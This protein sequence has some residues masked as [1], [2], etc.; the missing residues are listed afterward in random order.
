VW[1]VVLAC[2][3]GDT[4]PAGAAP[5]APGKRGRIE[6]PPHARSRDV[7]EHARLRLA[8]KAPG[9]A[10]LARGAAAD[11]TRFVV[12]RVD[13]P[14]LAFG[15]SPPGDELHDRFYY[16]N[17]FRY[18]T[19]YF[20]AAS[21]G[22]LHLEF[23]VAAAVART[24]LAAADYGDVAIYDSSMVELTRIAVQSSD[25]EVDFAAY[26]GVLLVHAGPGQESDVA[27][28]SPTQIWS[29]FLDDTTFREQ[30]SSADST[31]LGLDTQDGV[32]V[33]NVVIL[34]EWQ[35]QDLQVSQGTRLG[36]LGVYCH[37][38]GQ[39]LGLVP[40]FD[41][42]PRIPDSQGLGNF[43]L[44][45]YGLWVANG[46]IPSQP[47]AFN[48]VL[49][50]WIDPIDIAAGEHT[51]ELR[52]FER[53]PPDS[54]VL[55]VRV[56]ERESFLVTYVLEDP[57]GPR[58]N[59][60]S[61]QPVGPRRFFAFEDR[62]ANC[63]FDYTDVNA[64]SVLSPGD[65]ID[66]YAGAEWDFFMTDQLGGA[67]A[68]EGWGLLVLHVDEAV[69]QDVLARGSTN[70]QGDARRK[71]VDVEEADGI[72]DLDRTPD[73]SRAFGSADDYW[74]HGRTFGAASTPRSHTADGA[75]TGVHIELVSLPDSTALTPGGRARVRV[76]VAATSAAAAAPRRRA[77]RAVAQEHA[78]DLVALPLA[79]GRAALV[80]TADEGS[81][82][83]L[84]ADLD[85]APVPV[86]DP[87]TW[88]AW[89]TIPPALRGAW[90]G[91]PA[92]GDV[93]GDG[94]ADLVVCVNAD[95]AGEPRGRL[96]AWRRDGTELRD[97]DADPM[98]HTGLVHSVRGSISAPGVFAAQSG[99]AAEIVVVHQTA[100]D[101]VRALRVAHAGGAWDVVRGRAFRGRARGAPAAARLAS[102]RL[103]AAYT[104][105]DSAAGRQTV[106]FEP[107]GAT[108]LQQ[109]ASVDWTLE[110]LWLVSGDLDADGRDEF[111]IA[112]GDGS[113]WAQSRVQRLG[114]PIAAP[115]ALADVDGDGTLEIVVTTHSAVHVLS[116]TGATLRGWPARF[117]LEPG[118]ESDTAPAR[119]GAAPVVADLDGDGRVEIA[120]HLRGGALMVWSGSGARRHEL[121]AALPAFAAG[122]PMVRDLDADG[123][124]ELA[125]IGAFTR[126]RRYFADRDSLATEARVELAVF[127]WSLAAPPVW[128]ELGGGPGHA[129]RDDSTRMVAVRPNDAALAGFAVGPNPARD[130]V[131]ARIALTQAADVKCV[132]YDLEGQIVRAARQPGGAGT[133][134]ELVFDVR[135]LAPGVYFARLELSTG[136]QRVR[137]VA[138]RR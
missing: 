130:E 126:A 121:E 55:R 133:V 41:S 19:Q 29:G 74:R 68:G 101:T 4:A 13:F 40:L 98:T 59:V 17:Q 80:V 60:C 97:L 92:V 99:G 118:L 15:D 58:V 3:A 7:V 57:D 31:V 66:S 32:Q 30:L 84:D 39:R 50:G 2:A 110:R 127:T 54:T 45:A 94:A 53:G 18:V 136:G 137:P 103:Q 131:R 135:D 10:V 114:A 5:A 75:P 25:P 76:A 71:A 123:V 62:N 106:I 85:E 132:L 102:P 49:A 8:A 95:S 33:T 38:V 108:N 6:P 117:A 113:L 107:F 72:E 9:H 23:E 124:P 89:I 109:L 28:D 73:N 44:M 77:Q 35:V 14:D 61:G 122:T 51:I 129:F 46:F 81:I 27:G 120:Q 34:P 52:D 48:R 21:K 11:T 116:P 93:D 1:L 104:V 105:V 86:G 42:S 82:V 78:G 37:E 100:P 90:A 79:D 22:R 47:S 125:A 112:G 12:L 16:Q 138:L 119:S 134:V 56:S 43:D 67:T 63:A 83:L 96:F 91:P 26:D 70:V 64:D 87:A 36:S 128:G 69:L 65:D 20:A 24:S 115:P 111:V 88:A